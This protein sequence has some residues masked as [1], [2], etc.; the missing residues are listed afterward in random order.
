MSELVATA[1]SWAAAGAGLAA[2]ILAVL[3][4]AGT[5]FVLLSTAVLWAFDR[6]DARRSRRRAAGRQVGR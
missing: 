1:L 5:T 3:A 4:A 6:L 2:G